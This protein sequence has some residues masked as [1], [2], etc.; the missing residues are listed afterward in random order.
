M[1]DTARAQEEL[2]LRYRDHGDVSALG[3]LFDEVSP[4]LYR[5]AARWTPS[6]EPADDLVQSTF[7]TAIKRADRYDPS[8]PVTAW[9]VGLLGVHAARARREAARRPDP[10]RLERTP[11]PDPAELTADEEVV[12]EV[13]D[14]V[15]GLPDRYRGLVRG[16]LLEER[17]PRSMARDLGREPGTVRVQLHRGLSLLRRSLPAS[18]ASG[19]AAVF[20]LSR[21]SSARASR[22]AVL[23]AARTAAGADPGMVGTHSFL[24]GM[25][26]KQVAGALCAL[27]AVVAVVVF[28]R[29]SPEIANESSG[30]SEAVMVAD[31]GHAGASEDPRS[32]D[33]RPTDP[34]PTDPR[35]TSE[36]APAGDGLRS[37]PDPAG[38]SVLES[39]SRSTL[40]GTV[41]GLLP[42]AV[43][44]ARVQVQPFDGDEPVGAAWSLELTSAELPT[45]EREWDPS[46]DTATALLISLEH[47][48]YRT[49]Q[50]RLSVPDGA[51]TVEASLEAV[52]LGIVRL[53]LVDEQGQPLARHFAALR[54]FPE[55][56]DRPHE[57]ELVK[58]QSDEDG[59]LEL[60][61]E[62][63]GRYA[64][65][66]AAWKRRPAT[67]VFELERG[68][69][70]ELGDV[71]LGT[72]EWI[73][74]IAWHGE[75]VQPEGTT[76]VARLEGA[77]DNY[78]ISVGNQLLQMDWIG[79]AFEHIHCAN[80][81]EGDDG[82]FLLLGAA[83]VAYMVE[84]YGSPGSARPD[85][86]RVVPSVDDLM[87]YDAT[88]RIRLVTPLGH[89]SST[90]FE[91]HVTPEGSAPYQ[92]RWSPARGIDCTIA[93]ESGRS[94]HLVVT[95][96]D[97]AEYELD[98]EAPEPGSVL[99]VEVPLEGGPV[100][101]LT[102]VDPVGAPEL[103]GLEF[104][105]RV[106]AEDGYSVGG[107]GRF[108]AQGEAVVLAAGSLPVGDYRLN[109]TPI[110]EVTP[111]TLFPDSSIRIAEG[112][113]HRVH[114]AG[115]AAGGVPISVLGF[116]GEP[117][118]ARVTYD[119]GVPSAV[120]SIWGGVRRLRNH[121]ASVDARYESLLVLPP[122]Q[123]KLRVS[124]S[125]HS[126]REITVDVPAGG[127]SERLTLRLE[128]APEDDV[129]AG[130]GEL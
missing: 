5:L 109:L 45:F 8:R 21:R 1:T 130:P 43:G 118:S 97:G 53:R 88:G 76:V 35:P 39:E 22:R 14:A 11:V 54:A 15:D 70:V 42:E 98:V 107:S 124:S 30:G 75:G 36:D 83:P 78:S 104:L 51:A 17:S 81:I 102:L 65:V 85:P 61:V 72:G 116:D 6:A 120:E 127:I 86:V 46:S 3:Q 126:P 2:F 4:E 59:V 128:R 20:A 29:D 12:Q 122:G 113:Q 18:F 38:R 69:V 121:D 112:G 9:L 100:G 68:S 129:P 24:G 103:E 108:A 26:M 34:Q 96:P 125:G 60:A 91:V 110:N 74:G 105:W 63:S 64:L 23:E 93:M 50:V 71:E 47:P 31:L 99:E 123:R 56:A 82:R 101:E 48:L 55:D 80:R 84:V 90:G 95:A 44:E 57:E 111:T 19:L 7:L 92:R 10:K 115:V 41:V 119:D 73:E 114:A 49:E 106:T 37:I 89:R 58:S 52:P 79:G 33:P 25:L 40:V 67:R 13:T 94:A 117:I 62:E 16:S 66:S 28:D 77:V 87:L 32:T 27:V